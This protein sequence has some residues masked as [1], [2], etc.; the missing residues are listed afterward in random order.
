VSSQSGKGCG[1]AT[2]GSFVVF[3]GGG[4]LLSASFQPGKGGDG[5]HGGSGLVGEKGYVLQKLQVPSAGGH[6]GSRPSPGLSNSLEKWSGG[7]S[8][9]R[10][11]RLDLEHG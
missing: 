8:V 2:R 6:D 3:A 5:A 7:C 11:L 4:T 1:R 10:E 9:R